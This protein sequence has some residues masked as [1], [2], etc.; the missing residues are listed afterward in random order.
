L[1]IKPIT[2]QIL[3]KETIHDVL[4]MAPN[5]VG[6]TMQYVKFYEKHKTRQLTRILPSL[7]PW[8]QELLD[9]TR[10]EPDG[11]S[12]IWYY[13]KHG[14]I[15]YYSINVVGS[16]RDFGR[17]VKNALDKCTNLRCILFNLNR[18]CEE[19]KSIYSPLEMMA[20]GTVTTTKYD[21][22][23]LDFNPVHVI[24]FANFMPD[25]NQL[26]LDRW[27]I[28]VAGRTLTK[29][30]VPPEPPS[31]SI[32]KLFLDNLAEQGFHPNYDN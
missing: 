22:E 16:T 29:F 25:V 28:R 7:L 13:D 20:D 1:K 30:T 14:D 15:E 12:I 2:E 21:S 6:K 26:S 3:E 23:T 18:S 31:A 19:Y 10:E 32:D 17:T 27:K 8:Q 24:V 4:K 9:E 11:R 5:D